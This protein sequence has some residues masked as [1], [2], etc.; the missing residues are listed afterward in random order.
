M[1]RITP[2]IYDS[3]S[4]FEEDDTQAQRAKLQGHD[5]LAA[6]LLEAKQAA[7]LK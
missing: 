6:R 2:A 1:Y 4:E 5:D 3:M 7:A